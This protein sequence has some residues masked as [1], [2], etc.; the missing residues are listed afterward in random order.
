LAALETRREGTGIVVESS[1]SGWE[2]E[3]EAVPFP[4]DRED[5]DA[6]AGSEERSMSRDERRVPSLLS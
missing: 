6:A 5:E 2:Y 4:M 1:R 3:N